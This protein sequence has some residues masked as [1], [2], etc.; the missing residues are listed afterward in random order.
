M[1]RTL[2]TLGLLTAAA[3][4]W[5]GAQFPIGDAV[6]REG[7]TIAASY[8]TGVQM[9]KNPAGMGTGQ[10]A[11]NLQADIHATAGESHGFARDAWIPYLSISFSLTRDGAPTYK[12]NGLLYPLA[13]KD[14][15]HYAANVDMAGPGTYHLATIISPPS[16]H[17]L[18]RHTD[19]ANGVPE[20]W[21]PISLNWTFTYPDKSK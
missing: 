10:D 19:K 12:K 14:G 11:V 6:E 21:K 16:S 2:I 5:A 20:W 1:R 3:P 8:L 15:P 4:A 7:M 17:G 9:D 13:A 18:L